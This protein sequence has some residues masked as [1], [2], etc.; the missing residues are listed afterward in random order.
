MKITV[1]GALPWRARDTERRMADGST[2]LLRWSVVD[3]HGNEMIADMPDAEQRQRV[4][5]AVNALPSAI[6]RPLPPDV[7]YLDPMSI[8]LAARDILPVALEA[9]EEAIGEK[10]DVLRDLIRRVKIVTRGRN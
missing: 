7:D 10:D 4:I 3:A 9:R 1:F 8:L 2:E 6:G 5:A